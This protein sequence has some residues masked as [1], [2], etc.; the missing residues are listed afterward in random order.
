MPERPDENEEA[1]RIVESTTEQPDD[2]PADIEATWAKWSKG[3]QGCDDRTMTLLRA[4]F[5]AGVAAVDPA[6]ELGRLGAQKGGHA[7]AAKL[8]EKRRKAIAK[9]AAKARWK[10]E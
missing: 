8:S 10:R 1:A 9:K 7:R 6:T 2:L 5:E 4:A 3:I